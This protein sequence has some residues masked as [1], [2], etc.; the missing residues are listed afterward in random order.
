MKYIITL[1]SL[2]LGLVAQAGR[3]EMPEFNTLVVVGNA[4]VFLTPDDYPGYI[5][6]DGS[7][8]SITSIWS[9]SS[10]VLVMNSN[11]PK[12]IRISSRSL[13]SVTLTSNATFIADGEMEVQKMVLSGT[14]QCTFNIPR[15]TATNV[16][17]SLVNKSSITIGKAMN[18]QLGLSA[19]GAS[20]MDISG[21]DCGTVSAVAGDN[22]V[23]NLSGRCGKKNIVLINDGVINTKGLIEE[24]R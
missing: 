4:T 2:A 20:T 8:E 17:I 14:D 24:G 1:I 22:S 6:V 19:L 11:P 9:D 23:I 10:L 15:L 21:L 18:Q 5:D 13:S 12:A 3:K 7:E 16:S